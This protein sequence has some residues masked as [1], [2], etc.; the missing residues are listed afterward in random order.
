MW[1]DLSYQQIADALIAKVDQDGDSKISS[2]EMANA[3]FYVFDVTPNAQERTFV[4]DMLVELCGQYDTDS[5]NMDSSELV[6]CLQASGADLWAGAQVWRDSRAGDYDP[7]VWYDVLDGADTD[8][9]GYL[10]FDE[11]MTAI[12]NYL[13]FTMLAG[14]KTQFQSDL[15]TLCAEYDEDNS[16]SMDYEEVA[17]CL[18]NHGQWIWEEMS[19]YK[20]ASAN[21]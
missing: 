13:G 10:T 8:A 17:E 2:V 7:K 9:D 6:N 19:F 1:E 14:Y 11:A 3:I 4:Q 21:A 15:Q 20:A 5:D 16:G 18:T 12:E